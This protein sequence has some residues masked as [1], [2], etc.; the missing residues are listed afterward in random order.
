VTTTSIWVLLLTSLMLSAAGEASPGKVAP[1]PAPEPAPSEV[2]PTNQPAPKP[3]DFADVEAKAKE[4]AKQSYARDEGDMPEYLSKLNYDQYRDIRYKTEKS[5]WRDEGLPFQIQT[6]HRGF[7]FR[8]RVTINILDHGSTTRIG[9]AQDLFDF[10]NNQLPSPLPEDL[11]FAGLRFHYPLKRDETFDEIAVFLGASY[12]RAVG[13]GQAFGLSARGLA[14][15]TGLPKEEEFPIFREFWIEKPEKDANSL[16]VY[17][18]LD[19]PSVAGAYRFVIRPGLNLGMDVYSHLY[20]RKSVERLG[21]APLTSMFLHGENTNRFADDFRPEV[22]DSDGL[23]IGKSTGE[24]LWRPLNNPRQL[25]ISVFTDTKPSGF[26]LLSRDRNFDHYQD[27]EAAYHLRPSAWIEP[28]GDWGAGGVYLIEI[29]SEAEKYDNIVAF[30]V[31]DQ[32]AVEGSEFRYDYR[33]HFVTDEFTAPGGGKVVSTR[34]GAVEG[35]AGKYKFVVDFTSPLLKLLSPKA[36]VVA[37]VSAVGTI[38]NT[39]VHKNEINGTWRLSFDL[40]PEKG[41]NPTELRA[42]LRVGKDILT[43][44]WVYQWNVP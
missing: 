33:L 23:L 29:P 12:F 16:T 37:E 28:L 20:L 18:L 9:Y 36:N 4:L 38:S 8:D 19:S 34:V 22:H 26:G 6:F 15:D 32:P 11:G 10:G 43:E 41:R 24:W 21:I 1:P 17:A 25:R 5:L 3:F 30:W 13:L 27:L 2:V 31:P 14:I 39:V 40:Q 7:I 44:S 42:V 35:E